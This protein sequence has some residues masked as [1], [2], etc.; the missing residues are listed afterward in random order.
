MVPGLTG[1]TNSEIL[2]LLK[3]KMTNH[4]TCYLGPCWEYYQHKDG[5]VEFKKLYS[6]RVNREIRYALTEGEAIQLVSRETIRR[7]RDENNNSSRRAHLQNLGRQL[8]VL[9]F[10]V[11]P[12][13]KLGETQ[14]LELKST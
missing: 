2:A 13:Y 4:D 3:N 12:I 6:Y 14:R 7:N 9:R 5:K 11:K 10:V 8:P 1:M